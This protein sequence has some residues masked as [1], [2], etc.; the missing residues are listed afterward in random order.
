MRFVALDGLEGLVD[1]VDFQFSPHEIHIVLEGLR[2]VP[3]E[4]LSILSS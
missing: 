2:L 1:C 3:P 4:V